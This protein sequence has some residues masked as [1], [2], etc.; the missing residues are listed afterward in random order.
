MKF[1]IDW[2]DRHYPRIVRAD[3]DEEGK[4]FTE[5]K[6]ELYL[7]IQENRKHW[8]EQAKKVRQMKI[9]DVK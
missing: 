5:C 9:E 7:A 3:S 8:T 4:S 6:V 1:A 2:E